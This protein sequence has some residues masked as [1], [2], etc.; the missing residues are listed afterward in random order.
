MIK[1]LAKTAA[2]A[3]VLMFPLFGVSMLSAQA[4]STSS[5]YEL[6]CEG[7]QSTLRTSVRNRD[8][9]TRVDRL[10]A[11]RY[12]EKN[13]DA[14][15]QR[16]ENNNQPQAEQLRELTTQLDMLIEQFTANYEDYDVARDSVSDIKG[17]RGNF[18]NF[19]KNLYDARAKRA[20]VATDVSDVHSLLDSDVRNQLSVLLGALQQQELA[21][22]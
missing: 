6:R 18:E 21:N 8:L 13:L 4:Q 14:F 19:Q 10:Q 20:E 3:L 16:L 22:D 17:C 2:L 9:H 12:I 15:T 11:Y 7:A 5:D 1:L